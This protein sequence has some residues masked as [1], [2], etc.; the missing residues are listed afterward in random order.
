MIIPDLNLI[1]YAHDP[2]SSR[3]S[4]AVRWWADLLNSKRPVG[5]AW[6]TILGF[7]RLSTHPRLIANPMTPQEAMARVKSWLVVPSVRIVTPGEEHARHFFDLIESVGVAG[8]LT[9]D[10][11]LAA[12]AIEYQ[13]ELASTDADF[14]RFPGLRWMNPIR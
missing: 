9:T 7:L 2:L 4:A 11:H 13:A 14:G 1:I 8:N 3:H 10:A 6:V 5:L 12:I